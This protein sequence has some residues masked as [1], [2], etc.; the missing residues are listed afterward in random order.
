[1]LEQSFI[2]KKQNNNSAYLHAIVARAFNKF[3]S[4]GSS[5][6]SDVVAPIIVLSV[7]LSQMVFVWK[8]SQNFGGFSLV[9]TNLW[10]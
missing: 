10:L 1:M 8:F 7:V 9:V 5:T 4:N 3:P 2:K 6:L